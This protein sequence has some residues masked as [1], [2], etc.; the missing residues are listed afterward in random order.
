MNREI[1]FRGKMT[2]ENEWIFGTIL[3]IPAPPVCFGKSESDKYYIQFPDPRYTPDWD[4]PYRMVQGEVNPDTIGQ[5]TGLK[6]KNG[7]E[8]YEGDIVED[9]DIIGQ[10]IFSVGSFDVKVLKVKTNVGTCEGVQY[11]LSDYYDECC[12]IGNVA[13]GSKYGIEV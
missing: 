4:M 12:V 1:K 11:P 7:K 10:V 5:Y 3:R 9:E 13:E 8:I 2:P 6:D